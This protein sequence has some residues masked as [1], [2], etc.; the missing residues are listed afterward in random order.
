[1]NKNNIPPIANSL[2]AD[3]FENY[4]PDVRNKLKTIRALIFDVAAKTEGVGELQE[5]LKWG[6]PS[7][8]T[9]QSKSGSTIRIDAKAKDNGGFAIYFNCNTTLVETFK[10][11]YGDKLTFSGN[12][13]ILLKEN[14]EIP[15]EELRHC[16]SLALTYHLDE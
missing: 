6:E 14:D 10:N 3:V 9:S 7:Y 15:V 2:V 5:C 13:A 11:H 12:R 1:M 8:L 16:I 4:A